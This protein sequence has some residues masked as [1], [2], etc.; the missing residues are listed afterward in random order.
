MICPNCQTINEK[1]NVFCVNCGANV[2][3]TGNLIGDTKAPTESFHYLPQ[4]PPAVSQN[5]SP[6]PTQFVQNQTPPPTQIYNTSNSIETSVVPVNQYGVPSMHN[7]TPSAQYT[8]AQQAASNNKKMFIWAGV[9][10]FGLV[11]AGLGGFFLLTKP[12]F[13]AE[14]L[15]DHLGM[16]VQNKEKD[17]IDEIKKD[18][19]T[20]AL[21]GRDKLLIDDGLTS[22]EG[23][24]NLIL[25]SDGKDI[26]LGDLRLIQLDTIKPDGSLKQI[27]FQAAP[28]DGKP[29]MKR[30]RIPEGLANGKYAFALLDG[31][32][33]DGKH[34]FW[35]FQVKNAEKTNNDSTLK[36]MTVSIKPKDSKTTTTTTTQTTQT[37]KPIIPPSTGN[38]AYSTSDR[39]ILRDSPSLTGYD[40][41]VRI[42]KGQRV[43]VQSL[44]S[45]SDT[46]K[47]RTGRWAYVTTDDNYSGWVFTPLLRY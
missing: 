41:G 39:L 6:P 33:D 15:P 19:F 2:T 22:T 20:N 42:R 28:V 32:L 34:K 10:F 31:Y 27:D 13:K 8:N 43:Y 1:E 25:Y 23:N 12:S 21:D 24:P 26:P 45:N 46:W 7:F 11:A 5:L 3:Q 9:I 36:S 38:Y 30:I 40:T 29:E 17:K 16:F 47:G 18:D 37:N 14:M 44:S 35:S 4:P